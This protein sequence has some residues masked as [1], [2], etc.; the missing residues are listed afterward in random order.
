MAATRFDERD[1]VLRV[2]TSRDDATVGHLHQLHLLQAEGNNLAIIAQLPNAQ[3]PQ[4]IGK[5][6]PESNQVE[7]QVYAVRYVNDLAYV[8]TFQQTDPLYVI[9]LIDPR[10]PK[11]LGELEVPGYSTYLHPVAENL[12]LGV[13]QQVSAETA[14]GVGTQVSLFDVSDP[15]A[16]L[17][18]GTHHFTEQFTPLEYDYR[19]LAMVIEENQVRF[20]LPLVS[21]QVA[22]SEEAVQQWYQLLLP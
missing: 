22:E 5:V 2:L 18:L 19:A 17:L 14:E 20:S 15:T 13:G 1:G 9:D 3:H 8:V 10:A 21:W 4:P 6:D 11:M 16:P 7:E 12:L